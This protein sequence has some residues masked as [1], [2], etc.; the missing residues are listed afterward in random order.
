M[1]KSLLLTIVFVP[2]LLGIIAARRRRLRAGLLQ[3]LATTL[4]FNLAYIVLLYFLSHKW[5]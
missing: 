1:S 2:V 4:V 3:L 5:L